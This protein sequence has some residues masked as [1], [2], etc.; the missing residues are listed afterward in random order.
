MRKIILAI[1]ILAALYSCEKIENPNIAPVAKIKCISKSNTI[2]LDA[3][4]SKDEDS[5]E[6]TF[7]WSSCSSNIIIENSNEEKAYITIPE[8][9]SDLCAN[10]TLTVSD[11]VNVS[12]TS[13][14]VYLNT[15]AKIKSWGFEN[16]T[17]TFKSNNTF[18]NWYI[19]QKN[20]GRFNR[21]NCGPSSATMAVKWSN[22]KFD[23]TVLNAR[24]SYKP[25]GGWWY[26]DDVTSYLND[27][28]VKN[29]V[30]E[31]KTIDKLTDELDKGNIAILCL[32]MYYI[33]QCSN[34]TKKINKFYKTENRNWGHFIIVKG[35]AKVNEELLFEVYDPYSY[36]KKSKDGSFQGKDRLYKASEIDKSTN[37]WWDYAIVVSKETSHVHALDAS[38]VNH[39]HSGV[40]N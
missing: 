16:L 27:N 6:L 36:G 40:I 14:I 39:M 4:G 33:S 30:V 10:I 8:N 5:S 1:S 24:N 13:T 23:K 31:L 28:N 17:V 25:E 11:G 7:S 19:D 12:N 38:A 9:N 32:D 37:I 21:L 3:S 26:T 15:P 34:S 2:E 18:Y 29:K 22:P 35:Y 20:T